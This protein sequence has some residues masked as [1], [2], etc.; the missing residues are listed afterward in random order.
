MVAMTLL[1]A[2]LRDLDAALVNVIHDEVST[3]RMCRRQVVTQTTINSP[4]RAV[5]DGSLAAT[6]P[7]LVSLKLV[8]KGSAR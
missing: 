6:V 1:E 3:S 5:H 7:R 4:A 2:E 8:K